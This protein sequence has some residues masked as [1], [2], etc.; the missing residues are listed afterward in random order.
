[1]LSVWGALRFAAALRWWDVLTEFES[2]LSPMYLALSGAAF[3]VAGGVLYWAAHTRRRWFRS[4]LLVAAVL[5]YGQFWIERSL[6]PMAQANTGFVLIATTL[7]LAVVIVGSTL[8]VTRKYFLKSEAH[9]HAD[10]T[11]KTE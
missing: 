9:E 5:W 8:Q 11:P 4:A 10:P 6:Y 3:C 1:M 2:R 7:L